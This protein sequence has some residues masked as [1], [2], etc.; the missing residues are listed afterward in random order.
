MRVTEDSPAAVA[1]AK[2]AA[3]IRAERARSNLTQD[4]V[5][6]RM[7]QSGF[8]YWRQ[9]TTGATERGERRVTAAEL[10]VLAAVLG[11]EPEALWRT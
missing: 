5:A 7:R 1:Q 10:V 2:I 6:D 8:S 11:V 3:N 9:Q 4:T